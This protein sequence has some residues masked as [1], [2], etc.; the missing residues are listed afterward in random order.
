MMKKDIDNFL[1]QLKTGINKKKNRFALV[2]AKKLTNRSPVLTGLYVR[3]H[4][5]GIGKINT[6]MTGEYW[7]DLPGMDK[8]GIT[9]FAKPKSETKQNIKRKKAFTKMRPKIT[10]AKFENHIFI[11]NRVH[12]ANE[13]EYIGWKRTGPY[14]VY[15]LT[16]GE[17]QLVFPI[18]MKAKS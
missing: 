3:N 13:V 5:V 1:D 10:A 17:L 11:S 7:M 8:F 4:K 18:M 12:Y 14:H 15:G 2:A 16:S 6:K 9:V